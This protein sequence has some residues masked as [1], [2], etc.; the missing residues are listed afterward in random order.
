KRPV[1]DAPGDAGSEGVVPDAGTAEPAHRVMDA[2]NEAEYPIRMMVLRPGRN[3]VPLREYP[4]ASID[5][6]PGRSYSV[7]T[8]GAYSKGG[9]AASGTVMYFLEGNT[10]ARASYGFL[11]PSARTFRGVRKLHA[12]VVD[13]APEENKGS[14]RINIRESKYTPPL[15]MAFDPRENAIYVKPEHKFVLHNLNPGSEY[16]LTVRDD[17]AETRE[18]SAGRIGSVLCVEHSS[19][20]RPVPR[21][22]RIMEVGKRYT[23]VNTQTLECMFPDDRLGDNAGAMEI[24]IVDVAEARKAGDKV[25]KG[26][27]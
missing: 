11:G 6:E 16:L 15:L 1:A 12:F 20:P 26:I 5:L 18:G 19:E 25:G 10:T 27:R 14:V 17:F 8:E 24:D 2:M 21:S 9:K 7:W 4:T 13:S 22:H 23:V 3:A